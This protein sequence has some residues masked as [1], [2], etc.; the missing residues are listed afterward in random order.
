MR[1]FI[2]PEIVGAHTDQ[3]ALDYVCAVLESAEADHLILTGVDLLEFYDIAKQLR[4]AHGGPITVLKGREFHGVSAL[5]LDALG[6][7]WRIAEDV[8]LDGWLMLPAK[9]TTKGVVPAGMTAW[10]D[11][12]ER[13]VNVVR[14]DTGQ[15]GIV[16]SNEQHR[17]LK[18]VEIGHLATAQGAKA[19]GW[20]EGR[21]GFLI[22]GEN[23]TVSVEVPPA[24]GRN[25][26]ILIEELK[27]FL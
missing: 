14:G 7:D 13:G 16:T 19:R 25:P 11:A 15:L 18:G 24:S 8:V 6:G 9:S 3:S 21:Q 27:T 4:K 1:A 5:Y 10:K 17:T 12:W 23:R 26:G 20:S 22:V 2:L